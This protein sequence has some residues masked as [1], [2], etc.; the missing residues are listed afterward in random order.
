VCSSFA[1]TVFMTTVI[2]GT[3]SMF[4]RHTAAPCLAFLKGT[5]IPCIAY[6]SFWL[7]PRMGPK[8]WLLSSVNHGLY[9][10]QGALQSSQSLSS[11]AQLLHGCI[12][13]QL[14]TGA[15]YLY[16]GALCHVVVH[17]TCSL[18]WV[19]VRGLRTCGCL[20]QLVGHYTRRKSPC[21]ALL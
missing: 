6:I 9:V 12:L 19:F 10:H 8:P 17:F 11:H 7:G 14:R 1:C 2:S 13:L 4:Q 15:V 5:C 20:G 16:A 3:T 18:V 21:T